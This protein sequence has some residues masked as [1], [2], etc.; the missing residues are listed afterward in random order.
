ML[1]KIALT[2]F[3]SALLC[4]ITADILNALSFSLF[5]TLI[6]RIG[7]TLLLIS[8]AM[9]WWII[10]KIIA[11]HSFK[12]IVTYFSRKQRIQRQFLYRLIKNDSLQR[13]F[14]SQKK[15]LGYVNAIKRNRLFARDNAKQCQLLAKILLTQLTQHKTQLSPSVYQHYQQQIKQALRQRAIARLCAL[16]NQLNTH[17]H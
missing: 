3:S 4:L 13:L 12:S 9:L 16:Q 7:D 6:I 14:S 11:N 8:F 10:F 15:Q 2:L 17:L 1:I 5:A